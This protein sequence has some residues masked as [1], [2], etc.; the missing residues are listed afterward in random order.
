MK[1]SGE[2]TIVTFSV[3]EVINHTREV[4]HWGVTIEFVKSCLGSYSRCLLCWEVTDV[5][6]SVEELQSFVKSC[7]GELQ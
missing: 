2:V 7:F 1:F 5:K 6:F 4:L 3:G